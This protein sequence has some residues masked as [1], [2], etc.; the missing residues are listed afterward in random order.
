MDRSAVTQRVWELAEP[1]ALARG[2]E[3]WD[4]QFRPE[5][6]RVVVRVLLDRSEGGVTLDDLTRVSRELGDVLDAHEAVPGRYHLECSS[7]GLD[8]PLVRE[9]HFRRAVGQRVSVRSREPIAGR[10]G[11]HGTLEAVTDRGITLRDP[12]VGAV[13]VDFAAIEKANMEFEFARP[14]GPSAHA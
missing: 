6:G 14:A 10:R 8:R 9:S 2:L 11:F 3:L 7:P 5:G 13:D 4:V 1:L 12:D